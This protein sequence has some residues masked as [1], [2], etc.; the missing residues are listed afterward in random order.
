MNKISFEEQES[1]GLIKGVQFGTLQPGGI[2]SKTLYIYNS[3][4]PGN[5]VLDVSIRTRLHALEH[6]DESSTAPPIPESPTTAAAPSDSSELLRTIAI[7]VVR[8]FECVSQVTYHRTTASGGSRGQSS[9]KEILDLTQFER[10]EFDVKYEAM[11]V[12]E[13]GIGKDGRCGA[14]VGGVEWVDVKV[15]PML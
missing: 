13:L 12:S 6:D 7:P 4:F 5:R 9:F 1:T 8:P 2:A 11:V 15:C 14:E 10:G 3:G